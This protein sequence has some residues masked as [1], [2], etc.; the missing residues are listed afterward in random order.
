MMAHS[1]RPT[2]V[3]IA[4]A[5]IMSAHVPVSAAGPPTKHE[6]A[7]RAAQLFRSGDYLQAAQSYLQAQRG[8]NDPILDWNLARC[9]EEAGLPGQA[10]QHLRVVLAHPL[11][12]DAHRASAR[13]RFARLMRRVVPES[14]DRRT[15][16]FGLASN[17][18]DPPL[19]KVSAKVNWGGWTLVGVG[20]AGV[21]AGVVATAVAVDADQQ[22]ADG[23]G[24]EVAFDGSRVTTLSRSSSDRELLEQRRENSVVALG[25]AYGI[26]GALLLGG[27]LWLLLDDDAPVA[28]TTDGQTFGLVGR[29]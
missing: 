18:L 21:L 24:S 19:T 12:S 28:P 27:T 6:L 13:G 23:Q 8:S 1:N 10:I 25:V 14:S 9:Y 4:F 2:F 5:A 7:A 22:L 3:C 29:F 20:A 26:G 11:S 15:V 16:R 17:P